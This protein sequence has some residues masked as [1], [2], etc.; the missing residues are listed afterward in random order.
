[1]TALLLIDIQKGLQEL[2]FYGEERNNPNAE[3]QSQKILEAFRKKGW[4][5]FHIQHC[6]TNLDSP[7]HPSKETHA[8]Q[9]GLEPQNGE[10]VFP[11][12]V[13]SAFIGTDLEHQLKKQGITD[14]VIVGLTTEH[15]ISTSTRMAANLGFKTTLVSDATASF[16]KKGI[17]GEPLEAEL[18][19]QI[20]MANLKDEFAHIVNTETL[21]KALAI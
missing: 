6:S 1:M 8:F 5:V 18:V 14:V 15:C 4:P 16:N 11:K 2:G 12:E 20:A 13:N 9:S 3:A 7:L 19:H 10:P 21:L 17:H